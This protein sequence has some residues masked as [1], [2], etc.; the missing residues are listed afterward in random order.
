MPEFPAHFIRPARVRQHKISP[1]PASE[2]CWK[3]GALTILATMTPEGKRRT[4][5]EWKKLKPPFIP[6]L[7]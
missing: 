7:L 1:P 2:D 5:A 6:S 3:A 4:L